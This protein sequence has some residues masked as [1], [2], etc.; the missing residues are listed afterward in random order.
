M[1]SRKIRVSFGKSGKTGNVRWPVAFPSNSCMGARRPSSSASTRASQKGEHNLLPACC[2][3]IL[4]LQ[5]IFFCRVTGPL[6]CSV[7]KP[8]SAHYLSEALSPS[9]YGAHSWLDIRK[10][11]NESQSMWRDRNWAICVSLTTVEA[12][13]KSTAL[14]CGSLIGRR[15]SNICSWVT[16]GWKNKSKG[17]WKRIWGQWT[18]NPHSKNVWD[19]ARPVPHRP[20]INVKIYTQK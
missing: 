3:E 2:P 4:H 16:Q 14:G 6:A 13:W 12:N 19:G 17:K 8:L 5:G 7:R 18:R 15:R 9:T 20:F 1:C 10:P 11:Y